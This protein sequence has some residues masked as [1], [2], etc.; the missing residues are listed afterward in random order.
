MNWLP[1]NS[2]TYSVTG[3]PSTKE[4]ISFDVYNHYLTQLV[5]YVNHKYSTLEN[6]IF[7]VWN[8][9][10]EVRLNSDV[11]LDILK[12]YL[13]IG[14][15]TER[16][17]RMND[18]VTEVEFIRVN[19]QWKPIQT[20]YSIYSLAAATAYSLTGRE[21][22]NHRTCLNV[23]S[24]FFVTIPIQPWNL[25]FLGY[26]GNEKHP[27]TIHP[28]NFPAG[29]HIPNALVRSNVIP[30]EVIACCLQAEHRIRISESRK[31]KRG[32]VKPKYLHEPTPTTL[33]HFLYRLR[34]KSNYQ[35]AEVFLAAAPDG[36]V[37]RFSSNLTKIITYANS[38]MEVLI[39]RKVGVENLL[40]LMDEFNTRLP[41]ESVVEARTKIYRNLLH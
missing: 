41:S 17:V 24:N 35:S 40:I 5:G 10:N 31:P 18:E 13:L 11:N 28:V 21:V 4:E 25:H 12:K 8:S 20:Y 22:S 39:A 6:Y 3:I 37:R 23:A 34:I 36:A 9:S 32:A 29:I 38:Y 1:E 26:S 7:E 15:N 16:L 14:W 30:L 27:S 19:N 33:L 2:D